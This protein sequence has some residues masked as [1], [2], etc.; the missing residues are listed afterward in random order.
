MKMVWHY[1]PWAC[2]PRI[3][4]T[5]ALRGSNVGAPGELAMLWFSANPQWEPTATKMLID[6]TGKILQM[7]FTQQVVRAGC[8]RF[9]L[10]AG[11]L[12]L[13]DWR[14]ACTAAGTPRATRR[15]LETVGK[16][17]GGNPAHWFATIAQ[18]PLNELCLQV[19]TNGW[20]DATSPQDMATVWT[21]MQAY[22]RWCLGAAH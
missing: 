12:R 3:V 16:S 2:L 11:D 17:S 20:I 10:P 1:T 6:K 21:E 4:D 19:W 8:I 22:C 7:T 14:A 18:V 9:G 15:N 5:G 13:L